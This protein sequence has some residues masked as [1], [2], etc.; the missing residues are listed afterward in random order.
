MFARWT[1]TVSSEHSVS[2]KQHRK[3]KK[4]K[5][6]SFRWV[7]DPCLYPWSLL[8]SL[9]PPAVIIISFF[10]FAYSAHRVAFHPSVLRLHLSHLKSTCHF[11]ASETFRRSNKEELITLSKKPPW[12]TECGD[13]AVQ[14]NINT[15]SM[16]AGCRESQVEFSPR[17]AFCCAII[18]LRLLYKALNTAGWVLMSWLLRDSGGILNVCAWKT[19]WAAGKACAVVCVWL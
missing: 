17:L 6:T 1:K 15:E 13:A 12:I 14:S 11:I 9:P 4:T 18:C 2:D 5:N 3:K 10:V 19:T 8:A 7:S 16:P